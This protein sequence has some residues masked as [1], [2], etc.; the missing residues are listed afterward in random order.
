MV[1]DGPWSTYLE[2]EENIREK[3]PTGKKIAAETEACQAF[4]IVA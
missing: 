4:I 2:I 3:N 1:A